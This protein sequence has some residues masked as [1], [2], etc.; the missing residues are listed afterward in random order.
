MEERRRD[1]FTLFKN[2]AK[3]CF[4]ETLTFV[5]GLLRGVT[6]ESGATFQVT[7]FLYLLLPN[8]LIGCGRPNATAI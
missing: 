5:I 2:I 1:V 8:L 3:I 7:Y 4:Q 6:G